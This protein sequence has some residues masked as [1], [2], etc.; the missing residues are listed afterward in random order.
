MKRIRLLQITVLTLLGLVNSQWAA[1]QNVTIS[2]TS[3]NLIAA[4]TGNYSGGTTE[5]GFQHDED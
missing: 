3:G 5:V 1:A 2:P 4:L